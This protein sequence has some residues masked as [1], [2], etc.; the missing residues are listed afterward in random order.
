M[1]GLSLV[2]IATCRNAKC[3]ETVVALAVSA[4]LSL[5]YWGAIS[6]CG[7]VVTERKACDAVAKRARLDTEFGSGF[8][9]AG[10]TCRASR[11]MSARLLE[12]C[13]GHAGVDGAGWDD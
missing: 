13:T 9:D 8:L 7:V 11:D 2:V 5:P 1:S 4:K 3:T 6:Y 12:Q 10:G